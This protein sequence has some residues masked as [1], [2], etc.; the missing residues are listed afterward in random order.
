MP[1]TQIPD[2]GEMNLRYEGTTVCENGRWEVAN[3]DLTD[4]Q[5]GNDIN[6]AIFSG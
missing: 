4:V 1:N 5:E 6:L 2:P 3:F